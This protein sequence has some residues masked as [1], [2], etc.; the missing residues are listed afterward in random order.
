M[1]Y[2]IEMQKTIDTWRLSTFVMLEITASSMLGHDCVFLIEH[3]GNNKITQ[4][5]NN[6]T[7]GKSKLIII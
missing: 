7:K 2:G 5:P 4:T 3:K 1:I 6:L